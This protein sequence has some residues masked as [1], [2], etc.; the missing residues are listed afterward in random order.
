MVWHDKDQETQ[1][2]LDYLGTNMAAWEDHRK[3]HNSK[4]RESLGKEYIAEMD[5]I[6]DVDG[7]YEDIPTSVT[8][9]GDQWWMRYF[10]L[11]EAL[12]W[13]QEGVYDDNTPQTCRNTK[14]A[15]LNLPAHDEDHANDGQTTL[16]RNVVDTQSDFLLWGGKAATNIFC[17]KMALQ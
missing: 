14:R 13:P 1:R 8:V 6:E 11:T 17:D 16:E 5:V 9:S 15:D 7:P 10:G 3:K 2:N 4:T 12:P